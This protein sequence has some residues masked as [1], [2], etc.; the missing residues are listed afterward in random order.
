MKKLSILFFIFQTVSLAAQTDRINFTSPKLYPEGVCYSTQNKLFYV[1]S[2][3]TG[4]IG[5]VDMNGKYNEIYSDKDLKSSF[6]MKVDDRNNILWVCISDPNYSKYADSST[7]KKMA[8]IISLDLQSGKKVRDINLASLYSGKHFAN[9]LTL[10]D[11]GNLFITDSFS[12]VIYKVDKD[13]KA[14]VLLENNLFKGEPIGLNGIVFTNGLLLAAQN[15]SGVLFRIDLKDPAKFTTVKMK[16][17]FPGADG[18]LMDAS[19]NLI[20]V[21]NK[22]VNKIFRITSSDNWAS[23]ETKEATSAGDRFAN[24]TTATRVNNDI[25]IL[26]SKMHELQDS[27]LS[28]SKDFSIQIARFQPV[29]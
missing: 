7:H 1:S 4:T 6:G 2:V 24:P 12:P 17:F 14:S 9:D 10:D 26:N 21:Q 28:Q 29:K 11:S 13:G 25:Y 19:G 22:G 15:S 16:N 27:T 23:A 18:L 20:L 3:I 5:S 8:R